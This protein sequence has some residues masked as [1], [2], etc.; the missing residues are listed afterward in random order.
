MYIKIFYLNESKIESFFFTAF[1]NQIISIKN[2][3]LL[4]TYICVD[5][6]NNK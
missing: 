6:F 1:G 4:F 5:L 2:F 3:A